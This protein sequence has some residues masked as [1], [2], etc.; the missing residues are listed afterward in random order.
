MIEGPVIEFFFLVRSL[1]N[2]EFDYCMKMKWIGQNRL[3]AKLA[4]T[5]SSRLKK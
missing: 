5:R 4:L 2:V 3:D 1:S